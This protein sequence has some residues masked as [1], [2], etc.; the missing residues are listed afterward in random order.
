MVTTG[1]LFIVGLFGNNRSGANRCQIQLLSQPNATVVSNSIK[2][3]F[4]RFLSMIS[5]RL[6]RV[7]INRIP[8]LGTILTHHH[9]SSDTN[10]YPYR[11]S[12][13][14]SIE[15]VS[16]HGPK[17]FKDFYSTCLDRKKKH[18]ILNW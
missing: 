2:K 11:L 12:P 3:Q 6:R 5:L 15:D 10:V 8:I 13:T 18:V 14:N 7:V 17:P 9:K 4:V 1:R 16:S